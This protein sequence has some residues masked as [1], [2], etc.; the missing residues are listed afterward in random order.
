MKQ[1]KIADGWGECMTFTSVKGPHGSREVETQTDFESEPCVILNF[2]RASIQS[3][4]DWLVQWLE[5]G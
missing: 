4:S 1:I 3:L 2:D 5:Q